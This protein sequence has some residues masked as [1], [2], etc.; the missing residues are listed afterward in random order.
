[1]KLRSL[2]SVEFDSFASNFNNSN[3][4]Q[5]SNYARLMGEHGY[6]FE[7]IGLI[8]DDDKI[9]AGSMIL[10]KKIKGK[11]SYGYAPNGFLINYSNK[12]LIKEFTDEIKNYYADKNVAFIKINPLVVVAHL[13]KKNNKYIPNDNN[14]I[15]DYLVNNR[16]IKLKSNLYFESSLPRFDAFVPLTTT[17]FKD[18]SKNT[19]NKI[20]KASRRG[21]VFEKVR[22]KEID[23]FLKMLPKS[24]YDDYYY[25]DM[26]NLFNVNEKIDA[27]W[28][29]I[30]YEEY[31]IN[32]RISYDKEIEKNTIL[33]EKLMNDNSE[34]NITSKM[35]SDRLI[36][37]YKN[38]ILEG[39]KGLKDDKD[40][41]IAG[42]LVIKHKNTAYIVSSWFNPKYSK[43]NA[44]YFLHH[45]IINYYHKDLEFVGLNGLTGDLSL[46]SPYRGLNEFKLGFNSLAYEFIGEFDLIINYNEYI[47]LQEGNYLAA[48]FNKKTF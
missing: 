20:R 16:Y 25:K 11:I 30:D 15:K 4:Y 23:N 32:A 6:D 42:A 9:I 35:N 5:T 41:Y 21:L 37:A 48:E 44:N 1:M 38:D 7:Y 29:K 36:L 17:E 28:V 18:Y 10:F 33:N 2:T 13:D 43:F 19:R 40:V 8:N 27:F 26:Y 34:R 22:D 47:G 3:F 31:L 24:S 12:E 39:T 45:N 46:N 14:V